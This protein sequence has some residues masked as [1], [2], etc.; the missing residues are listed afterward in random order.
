MADVFCKC[1]AKDEKQAS[2][3]LIHFMG[4]TRITKVAEVRLLKFLA[5]LGRSWWFSATAA[6]C[7]ILDNLQF[8][9]AHSLN[10]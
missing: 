4:D 6:I 3:Q 1:R 9:L 5:A 8:I 2:S 7:R 10:L